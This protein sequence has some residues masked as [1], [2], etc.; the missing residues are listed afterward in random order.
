[1]ELSQFQI[2]FYYKICT[3]IGSSLPTSC[4]LVFTLPTVSRDGLCSNEGIVEMTMC[5]FWG[6]IIKDNGAPAFLLLITCFGES[7]LPCHED[8]QAVLWRDTLVKEPRLLLMT[9]MWVSQMGS[10]FFSP[11]KPS[12]GRSTTV[13]WKTLCQNQPEKLP[14]KSMS[15]A[16][17]R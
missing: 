6:L 14:L 7:H 17:G 9:A 1:M 13:L 16:N 5:D 8:T 4:S 10:E 12:G 2:L 3:L 15:T 11:V